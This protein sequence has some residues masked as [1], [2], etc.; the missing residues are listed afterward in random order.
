MPV[1]GGVSFGGGSIAGS[2]LDL[3]LRQYPEKTRERI[4]EIME[5]FVDEAVEYMQANAPWEDQTGEAREGLS[6]AVE[7][8]GS[9]ESLILYHTVDY[10]I[11]LEVR[12]GGRY[13][14]VTPTIE[15][16]GPELMSRLEGITEDI[17][18][19]A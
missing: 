2:S 17:I 15:T 13:A 7:S 18:Y 12:W 14:I 19:Y 16:M 4:R 8:L 11:W 9:M 1:S 10:G 6:G 3:G 5:E